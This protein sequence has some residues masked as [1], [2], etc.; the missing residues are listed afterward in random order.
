MEDVESLI[1]DPDA[2]VRKLLARRTSAPPA[3]LERLARD[4]SVEVR[5]CVAENPAC[6]DAVLRALCQDPALEWE[7]EPEAGRIYSGIFYIPSEVEPDEEEDWQ[8]KPFHVVRVAV[9]RNPAV[10][11]DVSKALYGQ[12]E[13]AVLAALAK[14]P[15]TPP[16]LLRRLTVR[17][18]YGRA[19]ATNPGAPSDI[20]LALA[21]AAM[22]NEAA[23]LVQN[24]SLPEAAWPILASSGNW[25]VRLCVAASPNAPLSILESLRGDPNE[26][27][28]SAL[29]T[30]LSH[31]GTDTE[32]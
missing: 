3:A 24:P 12:G 31:R 30:S 16:S 23:S 13:G 17:D 28:T 22:K 29:A 20:L 18:G 26:D 7:P 5:V 32:D 25:R 27:V 2:S 10:S 14:N 21:R 6:P 4:D 1:D 9:A 19:V 11:P 15:R 8:A